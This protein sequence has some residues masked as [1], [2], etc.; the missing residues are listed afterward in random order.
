MYKVFCLKEFIIQENYPGGNCPG[1][2]YPGGG[3][4]SPKTLANYVHISL[5]SF[6]TA[7]IIFW[8]FQNF[9]IYFGKHFWSVIWSQLSLF[10]F[11]TKFLQEKCQTISLISFFTKNSHKSY[12]K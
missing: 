1:G 7:M 2:N 11:S 9:L 12:K 5:K 10:D 3:G 6:P 8:G 4:N